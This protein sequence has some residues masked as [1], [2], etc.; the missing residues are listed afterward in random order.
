LKQWKNWHQKEYEARVCEIIG[1]ERTAFWERCEQ[2][3]WRPKRTTAYDWKLTIAAL[4]Q[5]LRKM[6]EIE[7][8]EQ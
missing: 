6:G 5:E 3:S 1:P 4:K 8:S 2:D 7:W